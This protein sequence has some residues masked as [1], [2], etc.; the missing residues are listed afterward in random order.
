MDDPGFVRINGQLRIPLDQLRYRASRAG[1]PGG[2][3]VN[4]SSTRI[5][6][7]WDVAGSPSLSDRQRAR[8]LARLATRLDGQ[9]RLRLVSAAHRSQLRN[10]EAAT[11]RFIEVVAEALRVPKTRRPTA[12][13]QASRKRRLDDKRKRAELKRERRRGSD[14]E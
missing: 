3:H 7:W 5:E 14:R 6:L 10:R 9:G 2:Q 13:T 11:A 12:P 4:T 1:G 8:L